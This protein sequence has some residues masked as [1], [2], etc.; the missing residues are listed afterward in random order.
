M[1]KIILF[2]SIFVLHSKAQAFTIISNQILGGWNTK[3]LVFNVN[4]LSCS[5]LGVSAS[6]VHAAVDAAVDLWNSAPSSGIKLARGSN[7]IDRTDT[8]PPTIYCSNT[9]TTD[10]IAGEGQ[11][12]SVDGSGFP[13]SG[14][15][16]LNGLS[17]NTAYFSKLPTAAQQMVVS[18]EIGHVLGLGHSGKQYAL[19]HYDI[20][21]KTTLNLSQDDVDGIS[22][23]NPR[24]E[25]TSG[26][27]GCG[28]IENQD[29]GKGP[30]GGPKL[31]TL[32]AALTWLAIFGFAWGITRPR[33]KSS[34]SLA[35][36][37]ELGSI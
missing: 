14:S 10:G 2:I 33:K 17:T 25:P 20:T 3:T 15:L 28:T 11:I 9:I 23:L 32:S 4:D 5:S 27:M 35:W 19:M 16:Q 24:T 8:N 18:H 13:N 30:P 31:G 26:P 12:A 7:V 1:R 29:S 6:V 37:E 34:S 21:G 36:N 22:W